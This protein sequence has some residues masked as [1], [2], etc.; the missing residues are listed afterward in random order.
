MTNMDT[1]RHVNIVPVPLVLLGKVWGQVAPLL[2]RGLAES[3][4]ITL[5]ALVEDLLDQTDQLWTIFVGRELV[6]VFVTH[7]F[8]DDTGKAVDVYALAGSDVNAW[9]KPLSRAMVDFAKEQGCNRIIFCGRKGLLRAY[10][11]VRI[12]GELKPGVFHFER[13]VQ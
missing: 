13:A 10:E 6:G 4:N 9:G 2:L 5:Q 12:V 3:Q 1:S 8:T 7:V 11:G